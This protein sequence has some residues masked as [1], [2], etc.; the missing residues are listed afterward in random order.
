MLWNHALQGRNV[1]LQLQMVLGVFFAGLVIEQEDAVGQFG[2]TD[3]KHHQQLKNYISALQSMVSKEISAYLIYLG[4]DVEV[5]E[6]V[7]DT[8]F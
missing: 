4:A 8:L 5:E 6:V 1:V 7:M 3:P 2:K